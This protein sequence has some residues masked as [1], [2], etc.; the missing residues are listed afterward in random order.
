MSELAHRLDVD[1]SEAIQIAAEVRSPG[2][3]IMA[4]ARLIEA[5]A[6]AKGAATALEAVCS[7]DK[8]IGV[9]ME[10]PLARKDP[11]HA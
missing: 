1:L 11:E 3:S 2:V 5:Y 8:R 6:G 7:M 9:A 10:A 4:A